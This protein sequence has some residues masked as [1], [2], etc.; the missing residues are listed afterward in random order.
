MIQYNQINQR[1]LSTGVRLETTRRR[2]GAPYETL[3]WRDESE[4]CLV[5]FI[6][7]K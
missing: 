4:L 6:A 1:I 3:W 5:Y 7:I 2:A